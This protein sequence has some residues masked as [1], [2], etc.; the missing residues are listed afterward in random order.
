MGAGTGMLVEAKRT[1]PI[2]PAPPLNALNVIS[3]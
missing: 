3:V 1:T 2:Y